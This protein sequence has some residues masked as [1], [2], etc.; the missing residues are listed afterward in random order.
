[1]TDIVTIN[2][3]DYAPI[4]NR[5]TGTRAELIEWIEQKLSGTNGLSRA[6]QMATLL[7]IR[8]VVAAHCGLADGTAGDAPDSHAEEG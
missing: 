1:M 7:Q 4:A 5:P 6:A 8:E 3:V 2:G